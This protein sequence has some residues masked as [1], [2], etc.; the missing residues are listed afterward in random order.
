V[1]AGSN[2]ARFGSGK[3]VRR[4][5]DEALL[6]GAGRFAD[7]VTLP[8]QAYAFFLRSPHAH[9]RI[10]SVDTTAA[11]AM[12]GVIAIVT[13]NDLVRDGVRPI[14]NSA[15][16]KRADGAPCASPPRHSLAVGSVR[17]V[18]E[19]IAAVIAAT[20]AEAQDAAEAIDVRYAP[21]PAVTGFT[22][23][24]APGAPLV[25]DDATGNIAAEARYG[26]ATAAAAAFRSAAH[27]VALDLENQRVAPCPIEPRALLCS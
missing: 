15:D 12:P 13:G 27:V 11:A 1:T 19:A 17:F 5:E 9:A 4:V 14:P 16:F 22:A 20:S 25:W 21:L 18:G 3:A 23:A 10:E 6:K 8:N 24:L 26:D 7:D 2:H